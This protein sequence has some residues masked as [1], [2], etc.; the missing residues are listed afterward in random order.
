MRTSVLAAGGVALA[1]ALSAC[2]GDDSS[3]NNGLPGGSGNGG[4]FGDLSSLVASAQEQTT[5]SSSSKF[6][7]EMNMGG[8]S[9]TAQGEGIY[10]GE[11]TAMSMTMDMGGQ[12]MDMIFVDNVIYMKMPEGLNPDPSKPWIKMT[13]EDAAGMGQDFDQMTEQSDPSKTLEQLQKAGGEIKDTKET[14]IDG[15]K[16]TQYTVELDLSKAGEMLGDE[17]AAASI[18]AGTMIPVELYLNSDNLP[19]RIEM[20]MGAVAEAAGAPGGD[21]GIVMTYSDWGTPVDI[22]APPA[23]QVGEMPS[24]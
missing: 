19:V 9:I 20:N 16:V 8:Q 18:P 5:Q 17:S 24:Y 15:Q 7:M 3:S 23:D 4:A 14:E 10:S 12:S 1:L 11:N 2:G 21:A 22:K 13:A 6:T